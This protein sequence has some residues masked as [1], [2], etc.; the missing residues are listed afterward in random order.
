MRGDPKFVQRVIKDILSDTVQMR[1]AKS[2]A[3]ILD[4]EGFLRREL[5]SV[6]R[7]EF[8]VEISVMDEGGSCDKGSGKRP[9]ARPYRPS[10]NIEDNGAKG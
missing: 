2:A 9:N 1:E 10:I 6:V 5:A 7:A 3:G 8:G 4:E